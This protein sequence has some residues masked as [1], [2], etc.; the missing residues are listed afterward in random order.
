LDGDRCASRKGERTL[1][2]SQRRKVGKTFNV[3]HFKKPHPRAGELLKKKE[4]IGS[5]KGGAAQGQESAKDRVSWIK[6]EKGPVAR[7]RQVKEKLA[8]I[9][10]GSRTRGERTQSPQHGQM[11]DGGRGGSKKT[12]P[13]Y[14][15][16]P[17]NS[18]VIHQKGMVKENKI[19]RQEMLGASRK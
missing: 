19:A 9:E 18:T 4:R 11:K 10:G 1:Y 5:R 17:R 8:K 13:S 3:E 7:L 2:G 15:G 6:K 14:G 16:A 12:N